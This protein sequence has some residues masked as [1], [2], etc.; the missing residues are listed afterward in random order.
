[1]DNIAVDKV[2]A[3]ISSF[4]IK[5][6]LCPFAKEAF[7]KDNIHYVIVKSNEASEIINCFKTE[8]KDLHTSL[9]STSV[10]IIDHKELDFLEY[11]RI[12]DWC[13]KE[14]NKS[15]LD[16][17]FQLASFHPDY[18]FAG[19]DY[20]DQSNFTNRSPYPLVHILSSAEVAKAINMYGD[21][22]KIFKRNIELMESMTSEK[23]KSYIKK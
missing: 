10:V 5:L 23:L 21:T 4:V 3:W 13:E 22:S 7:S 16:E 12:F 20:S 14:L 11:L 6:N 15:G 1:M 17:V 8:I 19:T 18:Q 9:Y 2:K